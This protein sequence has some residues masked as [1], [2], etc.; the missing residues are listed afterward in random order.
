MINNRFNSIKTILLDMDGVL[1]RGAEPILDIVELVGR[2]VSQQ[3]SFFFVTNNSTQT[4]KQYL[5][6][7][8]KYGIDLLDNQVITSAEAAAAYLGSKH[9]EG[10]YVYLVG[11]SGLFDAMQKQNFSHIENPDDHKILAVVAGLDR[12]ITY[13]KIEQSAR[14]IKRGA[15]FIGTNP[16]LTIPTPEGFSPG[17]GVIIKAIEVASGKAAKIIGKPKA[18]LYT[19]ALQRSE[20]SPG[21]AIMIG[22][23]LDTD[24]KGAQDQGI[25]TAL[26]LSGVTDRLSADTWDPRPDL[27]AKDALAILDIIGNYET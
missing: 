16:D 8:D 7:F 2:L 22:D 3:R 11:E 21:E 27:V 26:V 9:P 18:Y 15:T 25:H 17:A 14:L 20:S 5:S 24:I 6:R 4:V 1:W 13:P 19:L 10:G 12:G 23:R